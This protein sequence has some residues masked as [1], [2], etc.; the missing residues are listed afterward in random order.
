M[1]FEPIVVL[2]AILLL[3]YKIATVKIDK[4]D[5]T[6]ATSDKS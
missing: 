6:E 3:L 2:C 5:S 4:P 1:N